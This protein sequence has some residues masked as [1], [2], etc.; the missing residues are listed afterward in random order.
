MLTDSPWMLCDNRLR[1]AREEQGEQDV[2]MHSRSRVLGPEE[3][4]RN[5]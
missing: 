5:G 3:G 1:W 2:K 4:V